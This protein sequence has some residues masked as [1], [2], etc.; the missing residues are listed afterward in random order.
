MNTAS[1]QNK[2]IPKASFVFCILIGLILFAVATLFGIRLNRCK[3]ELIAL[4]AVVTRVDQNV[5]VS[6]YYNTDD[7]TNIPVSMINRPSV[8]ET[9]RI[10]I[11][12]EDYFAASS[13]DTSLF[14]IKSLFITGGIFFLCG[15]VCLIIRRILCGKSNPIL[16]GGKFIYADVDEVLYDSPSYTIRC[17]YNDFS[18]KKRQDY[19]LK[20]I[21]T[22]PNAYL[23][24]NHKK[25]K[26]YIKG[27]NYRKYYFDESILKL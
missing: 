2:K 18:G 24:A 14:M 22:N 15:T 8:G 23:A 19:T 10:Y 9:I 5:Y 21:D 20:N 1:A 12:P 17:H 11:D 25:I 4:D 3:K 16:E 7:Y 6:Y 26:L 27:K 13:D